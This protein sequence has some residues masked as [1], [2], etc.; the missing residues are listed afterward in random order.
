MDETAQYRDSYDDRD[1]TIS[2]KTCSSQH[3]SSSGDCGKIIRN[4]QLEIGGESER[5][6]RSGAAYTPNKT[7]V[8][9]RSQEVTEHAITLRKFAVDYLNRKTRIWAKG[10][11]HEDLGQAI[12]LWVLK[13]NKILADELWKCKVKVVDR[14]KRICQKKSLQYQSRL[15]YLDFPYQPQD[16]K[17]LEFPEGI[18]NE[19]ETAMIKAKIIDSRPHTEVAM[20]F[21]VS[22]QWLTIKVRTALDKLKVYY[23]KHGLQWEVR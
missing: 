7:T 19:V 15:E 16:Y 10:Y 18:L 20:E 13:K 8:G 11:E 9:T 22:E 1:S 17:T 6:S 5:S 21:N 14:L 12:A 3:G 23:E 2:N 4:Q